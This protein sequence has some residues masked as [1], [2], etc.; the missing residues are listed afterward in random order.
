MSVCGCGGGW[1]QGRR[2]V[3]CMLVR[4]VRWV[5]ATEGGGKLV[6]DGGVGNWLD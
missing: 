5:Y 3:R 6:E 4:G 1:G 2:S